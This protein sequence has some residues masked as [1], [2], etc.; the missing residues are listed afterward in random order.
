MKQPSKP[1]DVGGLAGGPIDPGEHDI[2]YWEWQ[3]DAMIRLALKK[4]LIS[5]FAEM[6]DGIERLAPEDYERLNYYER[7]AT[8]LAHTLLGKGVVSR[9]ALDAKVAEI[10][11]RQSAEASQ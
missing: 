9:E 7:W 11:A 2:A 3:I 4:G 6:R 1:H 5:D 8:S 10:R